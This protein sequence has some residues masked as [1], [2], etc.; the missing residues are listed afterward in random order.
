MKVVGQRRTDGFRWQDV[1]QLTVTGEALRG[2][3]NLVP[4]G[5]YRFATF[6]EAHQWMMETIALTHARHGRK[7][8][9][10]SAAP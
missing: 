8:S 10:G 3:P 7:T 6:E 9:L 4:R 2:T 1:R 5:L